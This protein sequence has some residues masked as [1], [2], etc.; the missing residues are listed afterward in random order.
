MLRTAILLIAFAQGLAVIVPTPRTQLR[1]L[2]GQ[3]LHERRQHVTRSLAL[4][5]ATPAAVRHL[6]H[7]HDSPPAHTAPTAP[8]QLLESKKAPAHL[9]AAPPAPLLGGLL[10]SFDW[11][12]ATKARASL[13][14]VA[15]IYGSN[16]ACVKLMGDWVGTP[17]E[18]AVLRF[19]V[20]ALAAIPVLAHF[21][22]TRKELVSWPVARDGLSVG[23]FFG[24]G[25]MIQAVALQT[26]TASLQ[27]FLLSLSVIV[28]PML[29]QLLGGKPQPTRVWAA[30]CVAMLGVGCL[31]G[32]SFAS[33]SLAPG[34][35]IGLLQP[36]FF[37]TGFWVCERAVKRHRAADAEHDMALP[38]ALTAWNL[39]AVLGIAAVWLGAESF[40]AGSA[41][42]EHLQALIGTFAASPLEHLPLLAALLW[43]GLVTTAGCS[44]AEAGALGELSSADATVV[45]ATEPLWGAFFAWAMIGEEL[46]PAT[47]V[48][49]L[50]M[51]AACV[52]SGGGVEA[53]T[54]PKGAES[55]GE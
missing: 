31:E 51:V 25:Y 46:G 21:A 43:T 49:G 27:A 12:H 48:G 50:L 54:K 5:P 29:D 20:A 35:V 28:C 22:R 15:A 4:P 38:V 1:A 2:F 18:A 26:S 17:A 8:P 55:A 34:D 7:D 9:A 30:A 44:V 6:R 37:G 40:G 24:S 32:G 42:P 3:T 11:S 53:L 52:I 10:P 14:L 39:L 41:G 16:Y 47:A 19:S 45:F 23:L 33:S 13:A 36:L